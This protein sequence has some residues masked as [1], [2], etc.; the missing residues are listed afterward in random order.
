MNVLE[1]IQVSL[2]A[3]VFSFLGEPG[4]I[5]SWYRKMIM[6]LPDWINKPLGS[7]HLCLSGQVGLWYYLVIHFNSYNIIEHLFFISA[8][9]F[10]SSIYSTIWYY[11]Q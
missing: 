5:F 1:I 2:I 8:S 6:R 4:M 10:L 7:C 9:I 3:S 11:E